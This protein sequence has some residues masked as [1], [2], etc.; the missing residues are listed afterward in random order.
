[1]LLKIFGYFPQENRTAS[2]DRLG[3]VM[4]TFASKYIHRKG[5][6]FGSIHTAADLHN[7]EDERVILEG[8]GKNRLHYWDVDWSTKQNV[9]R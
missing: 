9:R 6:P 4:Y 1:M 7:N 8:V 3:A 2:P 5:L